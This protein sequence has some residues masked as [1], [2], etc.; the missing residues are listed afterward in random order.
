MQS[1]PCSSLLLLILPTRCRQASRPRMRITRV[2]LA[3]QRGEGRPGLNVAIRDRGQ[4]VWFSLHTA[5]LRYISHTTQ[6]GHVACP[7]QWW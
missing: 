4:G 2:S 6:F 7:R 1:R 5:L 3:G